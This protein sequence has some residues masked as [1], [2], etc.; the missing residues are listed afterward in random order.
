MR[1]DAVKHPRTSL[2]QA[3][4][5]PLPPKTSFIPPP[6]YRPLP[7]VPVSPIAHLCLGQFPSCSPALRW[8]CSRCCCCCP[9]RPRSQPWQ[10]RSHSPPPAPRQP[11]PTTASTPARLFRL[12]LSPSSSL[13]GVC[14]SASF[15]GVRHTSWLLLLR[16]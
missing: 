10:G 15:W 6:L 1:E 16:R 3:T 4:P 8:S 12:S 7:L 2:H 14:F 9:D 5:H 13:A 11:P